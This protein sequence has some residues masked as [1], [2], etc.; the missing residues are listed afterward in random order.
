VKDACLTDLVVK[1]NQNML[2]WL[3]D[4]PHT[5]L[6]IESL[7]ICHSIS[8]YLTLKHSSQ[9]AYKA[10]C[11]LTQCNFADAP[12]IDNM[13]TFHSVES[14]IATY[15]GVK[16]VC[17]EI[18]PNSCI[19]F[20]GPYS[21][22]KTCFMCDAFQWD[23]AQLQVSNGCNKVPALQFTI[24]PLGLQLQAMYYNS[25]SAHNMLYS[26]SKNCPHICMFY[27]SYD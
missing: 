9:S 8:I 20:M 13:L 14:C 21:N 22:F 7:G 27:I 26:G 16:D 25:E 5:S 12:G 23:Q 24:I 6:M 10:I 3:H 1:L 11:N 4:P 17:N 19:R 18:C 2:K 15:T